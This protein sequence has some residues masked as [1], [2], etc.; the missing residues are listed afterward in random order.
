MIIFTSSI[1]TSRLRRLHAQTLPD[2]KYCKEKPDFITY[3][4][5]SSLL[6]TW[7]QVVLTA[8][9]QKGLTENYVIILK[10]RALF[11]RVDSL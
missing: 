4:P 1:S 9:S 8:L 7:H 11:K 10:A 5:C 3:H 2:A 6:Q